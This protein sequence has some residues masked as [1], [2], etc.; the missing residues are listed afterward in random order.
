MNY[1]MQEINSGYVVFETMTN[2]IIKT[3]QSREKA[4]RFLRHLNLGGGFDGWT[5]TF[6]LKKLN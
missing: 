6:L 2:Q 4:K 5:P 3:F 1:K